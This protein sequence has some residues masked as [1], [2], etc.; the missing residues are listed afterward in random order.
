MVLKS[1]FFRIMNIFYL[2]RD[3]EYSDSLY[4]SSFF[5]HKF[6]HK[7]LLPKE[8]ATEIRFYTMRLLKKSKINKGVNV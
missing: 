2:R 6:H 7:P 3:V 4:C 8:P 5:V 1:R